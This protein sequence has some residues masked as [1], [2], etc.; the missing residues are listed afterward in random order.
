MVTPRELVEAVEAL[1]S[2][3]WPGR[4]RAQLVDGRLRLTLPESAL[5]G[6]SEAGAREHF[7]QHG[8]DVDLALVRNADAVSLRP[9][10]SD[11]R[12]TTF[13]NAPAL[14]GD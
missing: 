1:P 2:Q 9:L 4:F 8:L 6:L 3:P 5:N 13:V 11:L 14:I 7:A 12:E 10:R